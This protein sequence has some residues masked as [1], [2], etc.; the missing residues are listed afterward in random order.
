VPLVLI[1]PSAEARARAERH[2]ETIVRL[3]RLA[4]IS[5]AG[6]APKDAAQVVVGDTT[7]ALALSGIIDMDAEKARIAKEVAKVGV[8]IKKVTDRLANPQFMARAPE[9]VVE[10]LRE[11]QADWEAKGRRLEAALA[12]L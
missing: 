4:T 8:E 1:E 11:R 12:R 3:G 6:V 2:G 7:A 10:E 5:F 9:E